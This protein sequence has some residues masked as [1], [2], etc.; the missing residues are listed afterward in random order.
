MSQHNYKDDIIEA[1]YGSYQDK[2]LDYSN[3]IC[4][5]NIEK[6]RIKIFYKS[7]DM[8][9]LSFENKINLYID[10]NSTKIKILDIKFNNSSVMII[11]E[12]KKTYIRI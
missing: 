1:D 10:D 4:D 5:D 7:E 8:D 11:Y 6:K 3:E 12:K 9:D 2:Y